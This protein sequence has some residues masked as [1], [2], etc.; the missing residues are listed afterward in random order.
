MQQAYKVMGDLSLL[1]RMND[2][3]GKQKK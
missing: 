2:L 3:F 1:M